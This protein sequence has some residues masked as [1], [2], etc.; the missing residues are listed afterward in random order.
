MNVT[1]ATHQSWSYTTESS[2][3][4]VTSVSGSHVTSSTCSSDIANLTSSDVWA[5]YQSIN[6][7]IIHSFIHSFIQHVHT[8]KNYTVTQKN[9]EKPNSRRRL[10]QVL[11][12]V[13]NYFTGTLCRKFAIKRSLAILPHFKRVA[14]LPSVRKL[15]VFWRRRGRR[16]WLV[17]EPAA[18][19]FDCQISE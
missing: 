19:P 7:S 18:R 12:N 9:A 16:C 3:T 2:S 17:R 6:Q 8:Y 1:D 4:T 11:T 10:C 13:R 14:T 15:A 5:S